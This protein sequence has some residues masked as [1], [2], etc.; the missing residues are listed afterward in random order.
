MTE[1]ITY[2]EDRRA[3]SGISVKLD[4]L[5]ADVGDMKEAIKTLATAINRLAVVEERLGNTSQALERAFIALD[6][7]EQRISSLEQAAV[8]SKQTNSW[9]EKGLWAMA[10]AAAMY[11]AKKTGLIV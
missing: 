7:V 4:L 3:S 2:F 6:K 11:V 9:F 5:H 10:A 8:V 1:P